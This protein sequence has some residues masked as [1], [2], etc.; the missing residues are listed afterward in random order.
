MGTPN[1]SGIMP[2]ESRLR[3]LQS[4]NMRHPPHS[5]TIRHDNATEFRLVV[6]IGLQVAAQPNMELCGFNCDVSGLGSK[7]FTTKANR[8]TN[9][10]Q[11]TD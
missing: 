4:K 11:L 5:H 3:N 1:D 10:P 6:P 7:G 9:L 8:H 2:Q